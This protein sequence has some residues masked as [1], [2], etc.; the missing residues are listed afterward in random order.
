MQH[1]L[2]THGDQQLEAQRHAAAYAA[3]PQVSPEAQAQ[4][5]AHRMLAAIEAGDLVT[6]RALA[7]SLRPLL[8]FMKDE[9]EADDSQCEGWGCVDGC[10]DC[11][12]VAL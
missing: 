2:R 1:R 12:E 6:A 11:M 3:R 10:S 4:D 7:L 9:E 5:I 8:G